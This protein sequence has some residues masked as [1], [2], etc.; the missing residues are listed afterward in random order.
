MPLAA[1]HRALL[2]ARHLGPPFPP[3]AARDL[4]AV[5]RVGRLPEGATL[6]RQGEPGD[7]MFLVLA[8]RVAV[9]VVTPS[10]EPAPISSNTLM[11]PGSTAAATAIS[12]QRAITSAGFR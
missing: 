11:V 10:G 3:A 7:D 4:L 5:L 8:G 9:Q 6:I 1:E 2:E 12:A